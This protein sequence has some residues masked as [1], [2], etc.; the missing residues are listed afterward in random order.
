MKIRVA[1]YVAW[2]LAEE[3]IYSV[4]LLSGGGMMHLLD[5]LARNERIKIICNH[6]EQASGIAAEGYARL[7]G[8][9]G[10]C[11]ATSG[12]G[13]T[14]LS[15]AIA[16]AWLDSVPVIFFTGQSKVS[17]TIQGSR[18]EG[19]RQFGM[20][21]IDI[22][23]TV[24]SITKFAQFMDKATDVP[25]LLE[26]AITAAK[27]G[28][29][30]PVL[31]DFPLDIQGASIEIPALVVPARVVDPLPA[32]RPSDLKAIAD[33]W[34]S[35]RRPLILAGHGVRV[36]GAAGD[37]LAL[38][39]AAGIPVVTNSLAK[40][41][42]PYDASEFIGHPG[43]KGDRAGNFALQA[44]DL[45]IALGASYHVSTTG[46]ELD[47]F[48]PRALKIQVDID[49]ANFMRESVG[50]GIKV[51]SGVRE[52]IDAIR[53]HAPQGL[54]HH[55]TWMRKLQVTKKQFPVAAEPHKVEV[56]RLNIYAVMEVLSTALNEHTTLIADAGSAFYTV[57]QG[58]RVKS[59]QRVLMSGGFGAMGWSL[60]A[61]TGA[62]CADP[63]QTVIAI[64]GDGS[65]QTNVH[66]LAIHVGNRLNVATLILNNVSY[67][68][69]KNT[70]DAYFNS[71]YAGVDR[72]SGV[73]LPDLRKLADAYGLPYVSISTT[74]ELKVAIADLYANPGPR[75][76]DV[77]TNLGQ[78][79]FPTVSAKR[80]EDGRMES[81]PLH[82]MSPFLPAAEQ[83]RLMADLTTVDA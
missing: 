5:G 40:D 33:A 4:F 66:E 21:E 27:S 28:R 29:P 32:P 26:M 52:F 77:H 31:L 54:P 41:I 30:G 80:L 67:V 81:M 72:K 65:L 64:T 12:P 56:G 15:T 55:A 24:K 18:I 44:A 71:T 39:R 50:V 25:R 82:V 3:G 57:G 43:V 58:F 70:Q 2:R 37:L 76:L 6:H 38:A 20:F 63:R 1:D 13:A 69:I 79:I 17:Q 48:A 10:A 60:P 11:F 74:D 62:A 49:R 47:K 46:Y 75:L 19:L 9:L 14:N 51:L 23:P 16:G 36:A 35:A 7:S 61:A 73:F 34:R 83:E 8:G 68:S 59:G 22:L 42:L 45:I 53:P 78:E